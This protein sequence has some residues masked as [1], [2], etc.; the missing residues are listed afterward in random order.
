MAVVASLHEAR[1]LPERVPLDELKSLCQADLNQ[2]NA[3]ILEHMHSEI[4]L[5]PQ[6][7]AHLIAAGGK[8]LRPLLTLASAR[9]CGHTGNAHIGLAAAVEFIHTATLLHDD[10]VDQSDLRRGR[11]TANNVWGNEPSVLVGDFLFSRAFQLMV[12]S[13]SLR[14]LEILS[15]ASAIIAEGEVRQLVTANDTTTEETEYLAIVHAKTAALFAAACQV[16]AV[17]AESPRRYERALEVF[18]TNLGVAFQLADDYLDYAGDQDE[19][20]KEPGDD[21]REGKITLPVVFAYR[22]G[23]A[24]E[25]AFWRRALEDLDQR[26]GDL[27]RAIALLN[28]HDALGQTMDRARDYADA[29]RDALM[30]FPDSVYR[31]ALMNIADFCA[32]RAF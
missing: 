24:R 27:E 16:G 11:A 7:A 18:G 23:N 25:R 29:A 21:F 5:I 15:A 3:R 31:R 12:S 26:D 20:G 17:V 32:E 13:R 10:V 2:V 22:R 4:G 6:V 30:S 8:R 28:E 14:V 9:M 19:F 1:E